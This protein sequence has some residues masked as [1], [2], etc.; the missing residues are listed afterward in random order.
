[1][2]RKGDTLVIHAGPDEVEQLVVKRVVWTFDASEDRPNF[3]P[4]HDVPELVCDRAEDVG[5]DL[6]TVTVYDGDWN[7][8]RRERVPA[9]LNI[10]RY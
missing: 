10:E 3:Y 7:V 1:M 5:D 6:A 2:P 4:H 8:V 9:T